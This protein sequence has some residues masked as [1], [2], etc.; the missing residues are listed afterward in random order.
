MALSGKKKLARKQPGPPQPLYGPK[1]RRPLT[2][3]V[4]LDP[5]AASLNGKAEVCVIWHTDGDTSRAFSG[6]SHN[7][8]KEFLDLG[9]NDEVLE[10]R[11]RGHRFLLSGIRRLR[12]FGRRRRTRI[13]I[14]GLLIR[15]HRRQFLDRG[16]R[17]GSELCAL[18]E[19][20]AQDFGADWMMLYTDTRFTE[21]HRLYERLG[22][23]RLPGE[24][25]RADASN[26]I[27]YLYAKILK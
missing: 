5:M 3:I 8:A 2:K 24:Q 20:A 19:R 4:D 6:R 23:N 11:D 10:C 21:A 26:S 17:L 16:Q 12:P 7:L 22:Y 27:E 9:D 14:P 25:K 1:R 15:G 18:A 13:K